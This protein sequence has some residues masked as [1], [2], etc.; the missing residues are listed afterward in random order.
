MRDF[1][2]KVPNL[3]ITVNLPNK[4]VSFVK[5]IRNNGLYTKNVSSNG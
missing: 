3:R 5:I 4:T 1:A 2:L